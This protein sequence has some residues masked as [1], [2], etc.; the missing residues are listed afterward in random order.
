MSAKDIKKQVNDILNDVRPSLQMHGGDVELKSIKGDL[1]ELKI[2][3]ACH[4]CSMASVTF[5]QG[6]GEMIKQKIPAVKEVRYE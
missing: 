3:G 6:I 4:G 2:K 5:G 1:V